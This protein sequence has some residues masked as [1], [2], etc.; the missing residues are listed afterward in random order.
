MIDKSLIIIII[1]IIV[2]IIIIKTSIIGSCGIFFYK[3]HSPPH[4][5]LRHGI[6]E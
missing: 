5:H 6:L 4:K 3:L 2:I 1:I